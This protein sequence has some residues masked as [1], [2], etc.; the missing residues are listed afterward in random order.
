MLSSWS[1]K[2][3]LLQEAWPRVK[4]QLKPALKDYYL[5][6]ENAVKQGT[7]QVFRLGDTVMLLRGETLGDGS[8][9]LVVVALVGEMASGTLGALNHAR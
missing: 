2:S 3:S 8:K 9:E 5:D 4:H 1:L 7:E 6:A